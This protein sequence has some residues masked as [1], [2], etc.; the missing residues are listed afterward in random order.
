MLLFVGQDFLDFRLGFVSH[1][2][3][4]FAGVWTESGLEQLSHLLAVGFGDFSHFGLLIFGDPKPSRN[5]LAIERL[6]IRGLD[7]QADE[8]VELL[9]IEDLLDLGFVL[10]VGLLH[11]LHHRLAVLSIRWL[12]T[13]SALRTHV[14]HRFHHRL[15]QILEFGNL[16]FVKL[17]LFA[18]FLHHQKARNPTTAHHA[19]HHHP[20]APLAS[21]TPLPCR[22]LRHGRKGQSADQANRKSEPR[23]KFL[24]WHG[25]NPD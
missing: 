22:I 19:A 11:L 3:H 12:A 1:L 4:L 2:A 21:P 7:V 9:W 17:E 13:A 15:A 14:L 5:Q 8:S 18:D 25:L 23:H 24:H 6:K 16:I 20:A 10:F